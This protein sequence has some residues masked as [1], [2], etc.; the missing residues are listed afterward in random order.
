MKDNNELKNKVKNLSNKLERWYNSQVTFEHMLKTQR[1]FGDKSAIGFKTSKVKHQET[2]NDMS[3]IGFN[4]SKIKGKRLGKTRYKREMKK[5]EQEKLSHFMCFKCHEVGHLANGCPNEEKLKLKKE[6][7]RLKHVKCYKCR[8]WGHLTSMCSTKQLVKQKEEPQPKPQ[9][10]QETPQEQIKINHKD[11]GDLMAK[12]KKTRSQ[13]A[14]HPMLIQ[15]AKMMSKTQDEK[16]G[17]CSH[18][19]LQV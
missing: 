19:V 4:K 13:K 5:Q 18:Q 17:V 9:V 12:K 15:D 11:G 1:N 16:T 10:E 14:R 6:E 3:S 8:T 2:R 7:E